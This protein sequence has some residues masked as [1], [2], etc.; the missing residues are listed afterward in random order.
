MD[1]IE[2]AGR[3]VGSGAP[4]FVIAEMG[5]SHDGSLGAAMAFIDA[6]SASGADAVKFQAHI[7]EAE[8]TSEEKF[9]VKVFPQDETR[10]DYW[11]RTA[12]TENQWVAL[13]K[14][15]GERGVVFLCSPFSGEA[16]EMLSRVGV[17]AWKVASGETNNLPLLEEMIKTGLPLLV[18]TGMSNPEEIDRTVSLIKEKN[19]PLVLYQCT[20]RYPCPPEHVGL[21]MIAEFRSKY[22]VPVGFSD[23][24]GRVCTGLAACTLGACSVEVHVTFSRQCFGP[25]V[26]AS[27]TMDELADLVKGVRFLEKVLHADVDKAEE[28]RQLKDVRMLFTKSV[29]AAIYLPEGSVLTRG[30]LICKKPGTGI[31]AAE[32]DQIVGRKTVRELKKDE[33]I[34]WEDLSDEQA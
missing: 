18:S 19:A 20:N 29:V 4:F 16:V 25:D 28:A 8:G 11:K 1:Y 30:E 13:K 33:A 22:G 14:R 31:P 15:A 10:Q 12:F 5:L 6:A 26:S 27:V 7:A 23:H 32:L 2:I 24:T 9:R 34:A 3:K 17:P 21:N